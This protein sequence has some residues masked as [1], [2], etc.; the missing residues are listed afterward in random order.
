MNALRPPHE[1]WDEYEQYPVMLSGFVVLKSAVGS[2]S[3]ILTNLPM[4][5]E[6][7]H[8]SKLSFAGSCF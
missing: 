2:I 7:T 3:E 5:F 6:S 8:P 4:C 1:F